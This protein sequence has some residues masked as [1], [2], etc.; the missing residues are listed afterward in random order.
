MLTTVAL[1]SVKEARITPGMTEKCAF[2]ETQTSGNSRRCGMSRYC[3]TVPDEKLVKPYN[4]CLSGAIWSADS[5]FVKYLL[6]LALH[7]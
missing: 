6:K 4:P 3:V 7:N 5:L 2:E 1:L